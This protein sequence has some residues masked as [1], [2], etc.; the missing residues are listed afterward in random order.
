MEEIA[1]RHHQMTQ[2]TEKLISK[3]TTAHLIRQNQIQPLRVN[4]NDSYL[5][6][7]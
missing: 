6:F 1:N 4:G 7:G 3:Q 2:I 5:I